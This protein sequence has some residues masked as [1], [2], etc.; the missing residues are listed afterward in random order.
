MKVSVGFNVGFSTLATRRGSAMLGVLVLV[1]AAM[2]VLAGTLSWTFTNVRLNHRSAQYSRCLGAAEAA[3]EKA[4]VTLNTDY[5][6]NGQAYVEKNLDKYRQAVPTKTENAVWAGFRFFDAKGYIDRMDVEYIK[7]T[8]LV[9]VSKNYKGLL[10]FPNTFRVSSSASELN[11]PLK[12]KGAVLQE[13]QVALIPIYQ[14]A[15]FYNM[16]YECSALPKMDIGG[17]V[18]VN[19]NVYLNPGNV[20]TYHDDLTCTGTITKGPKPGSTVPP[21]PGSVVYMG[22]HDGKV[23]NLTLP[24]GTNN[25]LAAV[26]QVIE[27]PPAGELATSSMGQQRFYNKADMIITITDPLVIPLPPLLPYVAT[28]TSGLSDSFKTTVPSMQTTQFVNLAPSFTN[29]REKKTVKCVEIDIGKFMKWNATNTVLRP[30]LPLQDVRVIYISDERKFA[31]GTMSG[32]RL[33]NGQTLP[34]SGLTIA[35]PQPVYILGH[36]NCPNTNHL[37]TLNTS[38]TA[39]AAIVADAIT[40]LSGKWLDADSGK[41]YGNRIPSPTTVNA[42]FIAGIVQTTSATGYSGGIENF[43][44]FLEDWDTPACTFTYNGSMV[45]MYESKYATQPWLNIGVYYDPPVRN[46]AFDNNFK[47]PDKLPP[48]TPTAYVLTRGEWNITKAN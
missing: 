45:V 15:S 38:A 26:R 8:N 16:D 40:V 5:K 33:V 32:V 12:V 39:P 47:Y 18:H 3:T 14:F 41:G 21:M 6:N 10:G 23:S 25:S 17:T 19:G 20:L 24:I 43:P 37:G 42:A 9:P 29:Q 27:K 4:I 28:V 44:R 46:W 30:I 7:G 36:Y 35:T 2:I 1:V 11:T 48:A 34:A 31:S 22:A 13:V